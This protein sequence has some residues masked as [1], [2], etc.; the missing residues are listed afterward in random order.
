MAQAYDEQLVH[1]RKDIEDLHAEAEQSRKRAEEERLGIVGETDKQKAVMLQYCDYISERNKEVFVELEETH[2]TEK[3]KLKNDLISKAEQINILK[4]KNRTDLAVVNRQ[5]ML[6]R[7]E[8]SEKDMKILMQKQEIDTLLAKLGR[9]DKALTDATA[10]IMRRTEIAERWEYKA[11]VQQQQ[12]LEIEKVRKALTTQLHS[13]REKMGPQWELL[14]RTEDR[15][16]EVDTE[17]GQSLVDLSEKEAKLAHAGSTVQLMQKQLRE[18][19]AKLTRKDHSLNRAVKILTEF[20]LRMEEAKFENGRKITVKRADSGAAETYAVVSDSMSPGLEGKSKS[21]TRSKEISTKWQPGLKV[22]DVFSST[23]EMEASLKRLRDILTTA[24]GVDAAADSAAPAEDFL[25]EE[26]QLVQE[27][28]RQMALLQKNIVG[29]K[30]NLKLSSSVS[31][32]KIHHF[33][34][35]NDYLLEQVNCL[36]QQVRNLTNENRMLNAREVFVE[37]KKISHSLSMERDD[38]YSEASRDSKP[39]RRAAKKKD[40]RPSPLEESLS[41]L[42]L[43]AATEPMSLISNSEFPAPPISAAAPDL[44]N[45]SDDGMVGSL[46]LSREDIIAQTLSEQS[47]V[48]RSVHVVIKGGSRQTAADRKIAEILASNQKLIEEL[49]LESGRPAL[50][51]EAFSGELRSAPPTPDINLL[52]RSNTA[53]EPGLSRSGRLQKRQSS[54]E[55]PGVGKRISTHLDSGKT[56][57]RF[58]APKPRQGVTTQGQ[59]YAPAKTAVQLRKSMQVSASVN[60]L[61][62]PPVSSSSLKSPKRR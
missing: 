55:P 60:S 12:L 32:T 5:V 7:E 20:E 51:T 23:P 25:S 19:R 41:S 42:G 47:S 21:K 13:L 44:E 24:S 45:S 30:S 2:D 29:L 1:A 34:H 17:Y 53:E 46:G 54:P 57:L 10:E 38:D 31:A 43:A 6:Q 59:I 22:M 35:D 16:R 56:P 52:S 28:Q 36:R 18:L 39:K 58:G 8:I 49:N 33:L 61:T 27:Q 62:L 40:T 50:V 26:Q 14:V 15:L 37:A 9:Q 3:T 4:Q 11:G 48:D